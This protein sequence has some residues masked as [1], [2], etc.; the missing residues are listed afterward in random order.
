MTYAGCWN[1]DLSA[2][3]QP[4]REIK[5][6]AGKV[7]SK[8]QIKT[9]ITTALYHG[10]TGSNGSFTAPLSQVV[11]QKPEHRANDLRLDLEFS[12]RVG[13]PSGNTFF[14]TACQSNWIKTQT[15]CQ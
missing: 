4:L 9:L 12:T 8:D 11:G 3:Y 7:A 14:E 15:L 6:R 5:Q 2:G 1:G 10:Q 13:M